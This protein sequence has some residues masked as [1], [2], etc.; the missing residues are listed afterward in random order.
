MRSFCVKKGHCFYLDRH[1]GLLLKDVTSCVR[2]YT[3]Q[4]E[5]FTLLSIHTVCKPFSFED[6]EVN[7]CIFFFLKTLRIRV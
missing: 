4:N 6:F 2:F 7:P 5:F 3:I 1:S